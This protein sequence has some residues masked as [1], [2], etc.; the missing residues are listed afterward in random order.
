MRAKAE[1]QSGYAA[2]CKAVYLG[3]IPGSASIPF[4]SFLAVLIARQRAGPT[5]DKNA[6]R[7]ECRCGSFSLR[8]QTPSLECGSTALR[9]ERSGKAPGC[10][11]RYDVN[12]LTLVE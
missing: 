1:W 8:T 2:A 6:L 4:V 9:L 12:E 10:L 7:T 11:H 3:S 5:V